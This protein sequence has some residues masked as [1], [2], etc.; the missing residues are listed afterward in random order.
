MFS[1]GLIADLSPRRGGFNPD[2]VNGIFFLKKV[3][4]GLVSLGVKGRFTVKQIKL[5]FQVPSY[6]RTSCKALGG[7]LPYQILYS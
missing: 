4:L 6:A 5:K 2:L 1:V 3:A 7:T